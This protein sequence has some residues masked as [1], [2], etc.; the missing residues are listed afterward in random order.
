MMTGASAWQQSKAVLEALV[1][2]GSRPSAWWDYDAPEPSGPRETDREFLARLG[3]LSEAEA[4]A[5]TAREPRETHSRR[6]EMREECW[7]ARRTG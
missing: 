5:R 3:L 4:P 6:I 7:S 2:P 1:D